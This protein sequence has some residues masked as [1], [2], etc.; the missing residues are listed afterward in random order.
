M[1]T[2]YHCHILPGID[3]GSKDVE[4]SLKMLEELRQQ[5]VERIVATPH[6]YSH[7]EKSTE[8]FLKKRDSAFNKLKKSKAKLKNFYLGAEVSIEKGISE[9]DGIEKLAIQGTKLILL[10]FPYSGYAEWMPEEIHNLVCEHGLV[11]V[12]AH[13]H[14]YIKIFSKKDM[15][16]V[17]KM[18][19][20]FQINNEAFGNFS[21]KR[22][23]K[24]MIKNEMNIV[25]GSDSHNISDRK[26]NFDFLKR[27]LKNN[28]DLIEASDSI[29]DKNKTKV[30]ISAR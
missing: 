19:A 3:D 22:F 23:V 7:R 12:I 5:G 25:F 29:L 13:L 21:E 11:P 8:E 30:N 15:E 18:K 10:E 24:K 26:P 27:K 4:T 14:R 2:D 9:L 28:I 20:V 6:F 17:L 1:L 16:T